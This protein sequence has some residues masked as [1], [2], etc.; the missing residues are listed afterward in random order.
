MEFVLP[1]RCFMQQKGLEGGKI[2]VV[3]I[4]NHPVITRHHRIRDLR[5]EISLGFRL[6][7]VVTI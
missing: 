7:L 5:L 1:N 2:K 3:V 4:R 6:G